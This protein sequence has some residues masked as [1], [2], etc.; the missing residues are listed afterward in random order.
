MLEILTHLDWI[1]TKSPQEQPVMQN[2]NELALQ[3]NPRRRGASLVQPKDR[4]LVEMPRIHLLCLL[5][6]HSRIFTH[7]QP[8]FNL[9]PRNPKGS[10]TC[11]KRTIMG[12]FDTLESYCQSECRRRIYGT[13]DVW[14]VRCV[15]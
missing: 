9:L 14:N 7:R 5:K 1:R 6:S 12:F 3:V 8:Q 15:L 4:D 2:I 10:A 13:N 11:S